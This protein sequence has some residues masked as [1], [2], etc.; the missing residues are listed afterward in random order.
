MAV[1]EIPRDSWVIRNT[2]FPLPP[3]RS[4]AVA[5]V[6]SSTSSIL[7]VD[8]ETSSFSSSGQSLPAAAIIFPLLPPPV[9]SLTQARCDLNVLGD[10][11]EDNWQGMVLLQ[12]DKR[13]SMHTFGHSS[14]TSNAVTLLEGGESF[15]SRGWSGNAVGCESMRSRGWSTN[16]KT[17]SSFLLVES[18]GSRW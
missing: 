6:S 14:Y 8:R 3:P 11:E 5:F 13:E 10:N 2:E 18:L 9:A 15:R 12:D 4:S 17:D 16:G 7:T 1:E